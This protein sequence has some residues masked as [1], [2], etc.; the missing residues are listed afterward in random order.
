[1]WLDDDPGERGTSLFV[2]PYETEG[3]D[4]GAIHLWSRWRKENEDRLKNQQ[5]PVTYGRFIN[6]LVEQKEKR[7]KKDLRPD[8]AKPVLDRY[9]PESDEY[10]Q[11]K[12][13]MDTWEAEDATRAEADVLMNQ[14]V[15]RH[16][17]SF[18]EANRKAKYDKVIKNFSSKYKQDVDTTPI[19]NKYF[20]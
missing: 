5:M 12:D 19:E 4:L 10:A 9:D 2:D 3:A 13:V 7:K 15:Q 6:D 18:N 14:L 1:M 11:W 20:I 8:Y 16:L 17:D